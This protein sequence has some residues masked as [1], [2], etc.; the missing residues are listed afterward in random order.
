MRLP[1]AT[2][3]ACAASLLAA[4]PGAL[5]AKGME[6]AVQEDSVFVTQLPNPKLKNETPR[7]NGLRLASQLNTSWIRA[8]V[9]WRYVVGNAA[10][11][12]KEPKHVNYN[13]SGYDALVNDAAARGIQVQLTLTGPAPAFA[14]GNHKIGPVRPKAG[15]FRRFAKAAAQHFR[16]RV[17]RY[18]I[19]NEPNYD[20]WIAPRTAAPRIYRALYT[21]AYA[22]IKRADPNAKVLIGETAPWKLV[23]ITPPL[24]FLRAVA[25]ANDKYRRAKKCATL[26]TDGYA[27]HP[28]DYRHAPAHKYPGRDNV[29]IGTLGR[30][31]SALSKLRK[32]RLLTTPGGGTPFV[33]LTEYGYM[34]SG[35][36][37]VPVRTQGKYLV[38]AF[39]IAQ[40]NP[41]VKQLLQYILVRPPSKY[42]FFDTSI[43]YANGKP[44]LAFKMLATWARKA[45]KAGRIAV[46]RQP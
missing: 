27:H 35:R 7:Q 18:A 34:S 2:A 40:R 22:A 3:L 13:W 32:A 4:A 17:R 15:P 41:R 1:I 9:I 46:A 28:Y 16:G 39:T 33:Y 21:N 26:K 45:A 12:R 31:T 10:T 5:A 14:T 25:C 23:R 8:N 36:Y 44:T 29:T 37:K 19:F 20:R 24:K 6:V 11:K 42:A 30:L 38:K 43:A